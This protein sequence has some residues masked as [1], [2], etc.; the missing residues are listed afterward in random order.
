MRRG[1][2]S[3]IT[4]GV[5]L[6][7]AASAAFGVTTP[8]VKRFGVDIGM[9]STA[10]LLYLGA[11][12]FALIGV[13]R[14]LEAPSFTRRHALFLVGVAFFGA[15][16]APALLAWGLK[17]TS[18][19]SASLMLNVEAVF[20]V[21][22]GMLVNREAI[23]RRVWAA[24]TI[25]VLAG[26]LLVLDRGRIA[27]AQAL[28]LGAIAAATLCWA[29][30]NTL[31]RWL[32]DLHPDRVVLGKAVLGVV[33]SGTLAWAVGES[34]P[35]VTSAAG[36]AACGV[37]GYGASLRLYL[38]AQRRLGSARTGSVFATAPFLGA[39]VAWLLGDELG[40]IWS[41][42]AVPLMALGVYLHLTER[43]DHEHRHDPL[44]HEHEHRHDDG[45]HDHDHAGPAT[46]P[47]SHRHRHDPTTHTH[48]HADDAHHRHH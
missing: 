41:A 35:P 29:M 22:L 21:L 26:V 46:E 12:G 10:L 31:S 37:V 33:A 7:L 45:H 20:T 11:A 44:E 27:G 17:R 8:L 16:L 28:G 36:L 19:A 5:L 1:Y 30:D 6:A 42:A 32:A 39:V 2:A 25:I 40:G 15:F 34:V 23:G 38:L 9:F 47:H 24:V 14:R 4:S 43:H 13:G 48:P 18:G 3:Q